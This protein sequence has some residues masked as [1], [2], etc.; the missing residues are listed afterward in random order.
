[1]PATPRADRI[2]GDLTRHVERAAKALI[3]EIDANLKRS[4]AM[5]GTPVATGHAR[6]SWVPS[7]GSPSALEPSGA[8]ASANAAGIVQILSWK[9]DGGTLYLSNNAPYILRLNLG[10]S[11]QAPAGFIEACIDQAVA[12]IKQKFGVAFDVRTSGAGTFSDEAGGIAAGNLADAYNPM[13]GAD[14]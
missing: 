9:L 12:T 7:V 13:R 1:M 4:P 6:A 2:V 10:S 8:S 14:D 3:L 5:G 11:H